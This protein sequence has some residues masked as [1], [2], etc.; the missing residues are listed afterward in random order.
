[1]KIVKEAAG[2]QGAAVTEQDLALIGALARRPMA[3]EEVYTFSVR[4]CDNEI[5]RDF[6]RFA[7]ETLEELAPMFVG[8]AGIFDHQW[9]A[10][11]QAARIYKTE[12]VQEPE[13]TTR[14][15]DGYCWLKG[16]A[17]MVRTESDRDLIAEIEGGIKKEVSVGCAV[18]HSVCSVCCCDRAQTDCGHEK[19]KEYGGQ[20]CWASLEGAKD[21]YEFSFVAVPAQPRAG[22]VK[23][24]RWGG[25]QALEQ[26]EEEAALGRKYLEELRGEVVRMAV[27]A[28]RELDGRA[29]KSL[30][31]KLSHQELEELRRSYARRAGERFPLKTQL[32]YEKKHVPFDEEN[33]AF[34]G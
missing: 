23:T 9:S 32:S 12:V 18:E 7:P 11:G 15:G 30:A 26:L 21:A 28:D 16:C 27:L 33:K 17:Y 20:L 34:L 8:K 14:A 4:L 13:R 5:D 19:G 31:D 1:M 29:M 3:A 25:G 24:A 22:V 2:G 10:R 6:E